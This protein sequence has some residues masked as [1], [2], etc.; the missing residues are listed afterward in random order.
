MAYRVAHCFGSFLDD[1]RDLSSDCVRP[2][3][4]HFHDA[5][6]RLKHF[7]SALKD[8]IRNRAS[9]IRRE[10]D[11]LMSRA[12]RFNAIPSLLE[13]NEITRRVT[14]NDTKL[15]NVL[16]DRSTGESLAVIDL[17][18]VMPGT[19]LFDFGDLARSTLVAAAEDEPDLSR[20]QVRLP[21]FEAL[22]RGFLSPIRR[23]ISAVEVEMLIH[24]VLLMPAIIGMRF[25]T[26]YLE[27][28]IYFK[29]RRPGHNLSRARV[30]FALVRS[31]E[32]AR[33][34][35]RQILQQVIRDLF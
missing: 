4:P 21:V 2:S 29:V 35:M 7:R 10:T 26:D 32:K 14:H 3:I 24:S 1:L 11:F 33:E 34:E 31:A 19:V 5:P 18:T 13:R 20:I 25:L 27:G 16:F 6:R 12:E 28:D 15:N 17:D 9:G 23:W 30:Q 8:D 22:L